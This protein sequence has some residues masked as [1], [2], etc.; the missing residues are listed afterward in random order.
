MDEAR[1]GTQHEM[2]QFTKHATF[3]LILLGYIIQ[4]DDPGPNSRPSRRLWRKASRLLGYLPLK[5]YI[6]F[7]KSECGNKSPAV[8]GFKISS[9]EDSFLPLGVAAGVASHQIRKLSAHLPLSRAIH[10]ETIS[11]FAA[12]I[13][14]T[15]PALPATSGPSPFIRPNAVKLASAATLPSF[16]LLLQPAAAEEKREGNT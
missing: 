7:S 1:A 14:L 16:Y 2:Q 5:S 4:L 12:S 8:V 13:E 9:L 15:D 11:Q 6:V 3:N 10:V